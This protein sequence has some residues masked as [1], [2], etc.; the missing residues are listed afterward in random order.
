MYVNL[1]S[2][3]IL[4][5]RDVLTH[6]MHEFSV[7]SPQFQACDELVQ[8]LNDAILVSLDAAD[9]E[10]AFKAWKESINYKKRECDCG[11]YRDDDDD[12]DHGIIDVDE[13]EDEEFDEVD[14]FKKRPCQKSS[15]APKEHLR[16]PQPPRTRQRLR[17]PQ[18]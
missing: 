7:D 13:D 4:M 3:Q 11:C 17:G 12:D 8:R 14:D 15:Q 9:K 16:M 10:I 1:T 6:N 2:D 5:V 18:R